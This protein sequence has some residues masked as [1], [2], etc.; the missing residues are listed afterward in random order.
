MPK[1]SIG[2]WLAVGVVDVGSP[3]SGKLGWAILVPGAPAMLGSDLDQFIHKM[4]ELGANMPLAIGFEAPLFIPTRFEALRILTARNGEGARPWSA[5][6]GAS[7]TTAALGVVAYTLNGLRLRMPDA[8]ALVDFAQLPVA[9]DQVLFFEAFVT[10]EAK[11]VDHK[12]DALKAASLAAL[13]VARSQTARSA[14]NEVEPFSLLGACLLRTGWSTD[15][16]LLSVPCFVVKP[17]FDH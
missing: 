6:A 13:L 3:K 9:K 16:S 11:G 4:A 1:Q 15:I 12:D 14:I 5:G 10:G 17:G 8:K 2:T 7:V